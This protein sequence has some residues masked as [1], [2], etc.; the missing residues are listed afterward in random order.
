MCPREGNIGTN[1]V[2]DCSSNIILKIPKIR[3]IQKDLYFNRQMD[4]MDK[5]NDISTDKYY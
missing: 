2:Y 4:K 5:Q 1:L 3:N